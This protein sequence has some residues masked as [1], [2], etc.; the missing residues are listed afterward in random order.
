MVFLTSPRGDKRYLYSYLGKA[1]CDASLL[2]PDRHTFDGKSAVVA[3]VQI[4][5]LRQLC[6]Y[7]Y[8]NCSFLFIFIMHD[9]NIYNKFVWLSK[10]ILQMQKST[11]FTFYLYPAAHT[12]I[13]NTREMGGMAILVFMYVMW[14]DNCYKVKIKIQH[15]FLLI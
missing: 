12:C 5:L 6:W 11:I 15:L 13:W 8:Q 14:T 9:F 3:R 4:R 10:F 2:F 1:K 7:Y